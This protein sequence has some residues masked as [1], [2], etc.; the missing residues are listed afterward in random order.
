[1]SISERPTSLPMM[2]N[3]SVACGVKR[4]MRRSRSRKMVAMPVEAIRLRRSSLVSAV[5][6]TLA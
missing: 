5:S 2:L 3:S 1:M 4:L 6:S